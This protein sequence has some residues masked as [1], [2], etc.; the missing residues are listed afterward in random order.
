MPIPDSPFF[1]LRGESR[2]VAQTCGAIRNHAVFGAGRGYEGTRRMI[3]IFVFSVMF[4][5]LAL[6]RG[7]LRPGMMAHAWHDTFQ[8][9]LLFIVTRKGLRPMH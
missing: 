9:A 4:G 6:W 1:F 5:F 7:S 3:V 2:I 8:G